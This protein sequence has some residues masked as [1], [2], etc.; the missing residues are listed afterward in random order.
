MGPP[1]SLDRGFSQIL[2]TLEREDPQKYDPFMCFFLLFWET[3]GYLR[4]D[5]IPLVFYP[6]LGTLEWNLHTS[7]EERTA[8]GGGRR[9]SLLSLICRGWG[10]AGPKG[11]K[12]KLSFPLGDLASRPCSVPLCALCPH[13][14]R[15]SPRGWLPQG[16]G[17][18]EQLTGGKDLKQTQPRKGQNP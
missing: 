7:V 4:N 8:K 11:R 5:V 1:L 10:A 17:K 15:G 18:D 6:E 9:S 2:A 16:W 12:M 14:H 3:Q 13:N